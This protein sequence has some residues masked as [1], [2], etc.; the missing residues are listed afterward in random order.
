MTKLSGIGAILV[1]VA[2]LLSFGQAQAIGEVVR[3]ERADGV[4][5]YTRADMAVASVGFSVGALTLLAL[6]SKRISYAHPRTRFTKV[7]GVV[8]YPMW[9][10]LEAA[11]VR[12]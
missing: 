10:H 3:V 7:A 5:A 9:A 12:T 11:Y 6:I 2:A 8:F 4:N 1:L